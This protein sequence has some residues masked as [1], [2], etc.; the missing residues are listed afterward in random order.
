M[1]EYCKHY[2]SAKHKD[3]NTQISSSSGGAFSAIS[4]VVLEQGGI[5]I[6]GGYS[7]S[8]DS[9]EYYICR[10]KAERDLLKGSKY[11]QCDTSK[12]YR[13]LEAEIETQKAT[14][15]A[16]ILFTGTPC[17]ISSV[18]SYLNMRKVFYDN[19][20]Y[21]D[22]ICH[23]VPSPGVWKFYIN[24]IKKRMKFDFITFKDKTL[25]WNQPLAY[26]KEKEKKVSLRGFTLLYFGKIIMRPSCHKCPY[27]KVERIA[28]ITLGDHWN[29]RTVDPDFW[30]KNGVSLVIVNT[31]KGCRLLSQAA[32]KLT[33][34]ERTEQECLQPSLIKP[35]DKSS[36]RDWFWRLFCH[37]KR[38]AI[39]IFDALI[40]I[41][42]IISK[43]RRV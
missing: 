29:I 3:K 4:D 6:G 17:Q 30:D 18:K 24:P 9:V 33:I 42:K 19:L 39:I 37:N 2:Y 16:P 27:T 25:G 40:S 20:Y 5:V 32:H 26:V 38:L 8:N 34:C 28:D 23:G 35:A 15:K 11:I 10:T 12:I 43:L 13:Q 22:L 36:Y 21:C 14:T 41:D 1:M 7:F 31:P